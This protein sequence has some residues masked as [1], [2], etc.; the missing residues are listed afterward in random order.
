MEH[1]KHSEHQVIA[2]G[3]NHPAYLMQG[4]TLFE[5]LIVLGILALLL[6]ISLPA[7]SNSSGN[8]RMT[9]FELIQAHLQQARAHAISSGKPTVIA[10]SNHSASG[11]EA[12]SSVSIFEASSAV[13]K[14]LS[15]SAPDFSQGYQQIQGTK[16]A[17]TWDPLS[18]EF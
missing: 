3:K 11:S 4:F 10:F 13:L 7:L 2:A 14:D 5:I 8:A 16:K 17:S 1:R 6:G 12:S 18:A 9:S 15:Y